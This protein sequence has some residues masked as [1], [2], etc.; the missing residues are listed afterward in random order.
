MFKSLTPYLINQLPSSPELISPIKN[1]QV[2]ADTVNL[3]WNSASPLVMNY[4][5]NISTDSLFTTFNDT[6]VTDTS[7]TF[8]NLAVNQ[9]Y[10]WRVNALNEVGWGDFSSTGSFITGLTNVK[11]DP[12]IKLQ[13]TIWQNYPNPFNPATVIKFQSAH[14]SAVSLKVYD[15]FGNEVATLFN[16]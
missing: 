8:L 13:F 1:Q 15:V 7:A 11:I 10:F 5:V 12:D 2:G 4:S 3:I 14:Q 16:Q 9:K 6:L